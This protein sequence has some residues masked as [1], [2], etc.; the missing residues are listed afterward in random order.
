MQECENV[1]RLRD[2]F[3]ELPS[4]ASRS[5]PANGSLSE[6]IQR[7]NMEQLLKEGCLAYVQTPS[8][9]N[10]AKLKAKCD[11]LIKTRRMLLASGRYAKSQSTLAMLSMI[12]AVIA[13]SGTLE[14]RAQIDFVSLVQQALAELAEFAE[15]LTLEDLAL[16][17]ITWDE[18]LFS[19][20]PPCLQVNSYQSDRPE[21][22]CGLVSSLL[23]YQAVGQDSKSSK[24][25]SA[26]RDAGLDVLQSKGKRVYLKAW[27]EDIFSYK[28]GF[29]WRKHRE[30]QGGKWGYVFSMADICRLFDND[31]PL[32]RELRDIATLEGCLEGLKAVDYLKRPEEKEIAAILVQMEALADTLS[33]RA[34]PQ[35]NRYWRE[36]SMNALTFY[37]GILFSLTNPRWKIESRN[38]EAVRQRVIEKIKAL[39]L[40]LLVGINAQRQE[41]HRWKEDSRYLKQLGAYR[42][43]SRAQL[44]TIIAKEAATDAER[45]ARAEQLERFSQA[46]VTFM[47]EFMSGLIAASIAD[48]GP[49]PCQYAFIGFG[50][51]E[52]QSMTPYSDLEFGILIQEDSKS[53]REYFRNLTYVLQA[54]II[55]LGETPIPLS[56]F[57]YNFDHLTNA[58]FCFDLGGKISLGRSYGEGERQDAGKSFGTL[59]YELIGTPEQLL[60][61][62]EDDYFVVDK[63]LPVELCQCAHLAGNEELTAQY[64]GLLSHRFVQPDQEGRLFCERRAITYLQG[65]DYLGG[66]LHEYLPKLD[67]SKDGMLYD[68]KKEIYRLPDRLIGD[69]A[70]F[71][72][73]FVGSTIKKIN[74]LMQKKLINENNAMHLKIIDGIAKELRLSTYFYYGRQREHLSVTPLLFK[75]DYSL[76][77]LENSLSIERFY[78]SAI[79]FHQQ[80]K[81]FCEAGEKTPLKAVTIFQASP[82]ND[83]TLGMQ[84]KIARRMGQHTKV[85]ALLGRMHKPRS[86]T[87]NGVSN[88]L[89]LTQLADSYYDSRNFEKALDYFKQVRKIQKRHFPEDHIRIATTL[90]KLG[91]VYGALGDYQKQVSLQER[92]L[93]INERA[94]GANHMKVAGTLGNLGNGY[95]ALGDYQ[96]QVSSQERALLIEERALGA[97]HVNVAHILGN[98]GTGYGALGDYQKQVRLQER[99]L[100]IFERA[101]GANHVQVATTLQS[102]GS[103]YG[104]LGDYQKQVRLQERALVI[105]ERAFGGNHVYLATTLGNLGS[106]YGALGD[107]QKQV[108]LQERAL[109]IEKRAFGANHVQVAT[110][111]ESLGS[112]YGQLGDY[113]KQVRLQER[114]LLIEERAFGAEHVKVAGTLVNLGNGYGALGDYQK[115]VRLQERALVI[116]ERAFG[117]NHVQ[118]ATT[119]ESLGSGYGQLGDYQKQVRLQERALLIEER[120]FGAHHVSLA[121]T[122][123]NLGSAYGALGDYQKQ[124]SLQERAL[125]IFERAFREDHVK[126]APILGNVGNGYGALGDYQ[127]QV[128]LQERALVIA[129]R[130]F[131][132][133]HMNVALTLVNLG[134]AYGVLGDYQKQVSLLERALEINQ[135]TLGGSHPQT[136]LIVARLDA[137]RIAASKEPANSPA[138]LLRGTGLFNFKE[139][140]EAPAVVTDPSQITNDQQKDTSAERSMHLT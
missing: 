45:L 62:I 138:A 8:P 44:L 84:V 41:K 139:M 135:R 4:H 3:H 81:L 102:L 39:E 93:R 134:S 90:I 46:I 60:R 77:R 53:N 47:K 133:H 28:V 109:V 59:K 6:K 70:L 106:A 58:G 124:V 89:I 67:G 140:S 82:F 50:S 95:G 74:Q 136:T 69:V 125:V 48:C 121:T 1:V 55:Q 22:L 75:E 107:Y 113:Q 123:G 7:S 105:F 38:Q 73:I 23:I 108:R 119:L 49:A 14:Q 79:P 5:T 91:N 65:N 71:F 78:Q 31:Q 68:V 51:F 32:L 98:L 21:S 56:L 126:V 37:S 122:L 30:V 66:D 72:G 110:T 80:L 131:G 19:A 33:E 42:K 43:K 10:F 18:W 29:D 63:F 103:G 130:A 52:K 24:I 25:F 15:K 61:Y 12:S 64:L 120:A 129:E 115:Q 87:Q 57:D 100:V 132:E 85:Q 128:R 127:K 27:L 117:A 2:Q 54:K 114:A 17:T 9:E 97:E 11:A 118:V 111:L 101:F 99:A 35:E 137:A 20:L 104:Q 116:D 16:T 40:T 112:G 94:F 13:E 76:F 26:L 88:V 36:R 96:K 34:K 83:V 92:A 86:R